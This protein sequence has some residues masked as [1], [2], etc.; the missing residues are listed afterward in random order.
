MQYFR[1]FL[2]VQSSIHLELFQVADVGYNVAILLSSSRARA[3]TS[4]GTDL[5]RTR[6]GR[7]SDRVQTLN[8]MDDT[9]PNLMRSGNNAGGEKSMLREKETRYLLTT[10]GFSSLR[11]IHWFPGG[12][13]GSYAPLHRVLRSSTRMFS[14][15]YFPEYELFRKPVKFYV[16]VYRF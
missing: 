3:V 5:C 16:F 9:F 11:S 13:E 12:P 2:R 15:K 8:G 7:V 4:M 10:L 6:A 14:G 1:H